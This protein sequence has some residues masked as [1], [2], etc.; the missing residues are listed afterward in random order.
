MARR[1]RASRLETR[2]NRLKLPV[3]EKPYD[4]TTISPGIGLGYRRNNS[5]S[6]RATPPTFSHGGKPLKRPAVSPV[7]PPMPAGRRPSRTRSTLTNVI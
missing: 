5:T 4:F 3:R 1:P 2:T 6:R 7:G